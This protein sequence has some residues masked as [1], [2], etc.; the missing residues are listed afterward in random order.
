MRRAIILGLTLSAALSVAL[1]AEPAGPPSALNKIEPA[2]L[3]LA[4][5]V[6]AGS[7][8]GPD[9]MLA[10]LKG[11][12]GALLDQTLRQLGM[13]APT[14]AQIV[15]DEVLMPVLKARYDDLLNMQALAYAAVLPEDDLRAIAAFYATPAGRRLVKAQPQLAQ[16]SIVGTRQ[17]MAALVPE[18]QRRLA[19]TARAHGWL[20]G[21][22]DDKPK[23][24]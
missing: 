11:P 24:Q 4:R 20:P 18:M 10:A 13:V 21:T 2:R 7:Q 14:E 12:L 5:E 15:T 22:R 3:A 19:E 23:A 9:V 1:R 16:A 8:G 6:L 17:W